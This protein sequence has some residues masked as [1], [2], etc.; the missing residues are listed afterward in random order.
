VTSNALIH[1]TGSFPVEFS[2]AVADL[3]SLDAGEE[4]VAV[5]DGQRLVRFGEDSGVRV[6]AFDGVGWYPQ[7]FVGNRGLFAVWTEPGEVE[8]V[9]ARRPGGT[10]LEL[11]PRV[12]PN[13]ALQPA[14][15]PLDDGT[16]AIATAIDAGTSELERFGGL[17]CE[18]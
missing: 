18:P 2:N 3:P 9:F 14:I 1:P 11:T 17:F 8:R 6:E 5:I 7:L 15:A 13:L 4:V 10:K 12:G 16:F